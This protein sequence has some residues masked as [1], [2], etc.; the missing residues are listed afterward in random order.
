MSYPRESTLHKLYEL[1]SIW[2]A[3]HRRGDFVRWLTADPDRVVFW[4]AV[5][6]CAVLAAN[7]WL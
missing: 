5:A 2:Q 6:G 4:F 3:T 1:F 7:G